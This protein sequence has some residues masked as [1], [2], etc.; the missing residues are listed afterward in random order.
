MLG[1]KRFQRS[2]RRLRTGW[3]VCFLLLFLSLAAQG[4]QTVEEYYVPLPEEQWQESLKTISS[5]TSATIDS[6]ISIVVWGSGTVVYYD[7]WEDGY[8]WKINAPTQPG[9]E[10]WGDGNDA[11]GKPPSFARDP[12][13]LSKGAVIILR[14]LVNVPRD[15]SVLYDGRDRFASSRPLSVSRVG[16]AT[17]PNTNLSN[18]GY[19]SAVIDYGLHFL[20]PVGEDVTLDG[21]FKYAGLLVMA[22]NDDTSVEIDKDGPGPAAAE[23]VYLDQGE[24]HLVNGGVLKGASVDTS[25]PVQAHLI[26]GDNT[27]TYESRA[28]TLFPD[29]QWANTYLSPVG[30]SLR[31][32]E[33][34]AFLYNPNGIPITIDI[35]TS[36]GTDH[37]QVPAQSTSHWLI[38]NGSGARFQSVLGEAF[39]ALT[40]VNAGAGTLWEWG[41]SLLPDSVLTTETVIGWAPGSDD[42]TQNGS[43]VYICPT[44]DTR[45]YADFNGD[46][47]GSQIDPEG[48][49]YDAAYDVDAYAS[50]TLRDPDNDHTGMRIYT[51]DDVL[52]AAAWG[53]DCEYADVNPPFM[54]VGGPI[55]PG[56]VLSLVKDSVVKLDRGMP[57]LSIGDVVEYSLT[58]YNNG[59]R[60]LE[61]VELTDMLPGGLTYRANSTKF[62]DAPVLDDS[63]GFT[64]F[65][66]DET[67]YAV[68]YLP[69][70]TTAVLT[71][72]TVIDV[73]GTI[74][75]TAR[76]S[77]Y[78]VVSE[79][80]LN[81]PETEGEF[82][83][84]GEGEVEPATYGVKL[85]TCSA[86]PNPVYASQQI[87]LS[88]LSGLCHATTA[89]E[90]VRVTLGFRD[91]SGAWAGNDPVVVYSGTP[92][93]SWQKWSNS[94]IFK[95]PSA[96]G[97]YAVWVRHSPGMGSAAAIQ[98]FKDAVPTTA[99]EV[100]D[101]TWDK[102][103]IVVDA[104]GEGE[105]GEGETPSYGLTVHSCT[106]TPN[107]VDPGM[108]V[109]LAG[110][111]GQCYAATDS[112]TLKITA[113]FRDASGVWKGGE[114]V[115]AW[116]GKP[117]VSPLAW[118]GSA[119]VMAPSQPGTYYIWVRNTATTSDSAA[120]TDFKNAAAP[121][122]DETRNDRFETPLTVSPLQGIQLTQCAF[123]PNPAAPGQKVTLS[124]VGGQYRGPS[125]SA[126][127]KITTGFRD[128]SGAW[129][130]SDPA[131]VK[132]GIPGTTW[133]AWTGSTTLIAPLTA[134]TYQVWVRST[135][136]TSDRDA[137]ADFKAVSPTSGDRQFNDTW[138]TS[139][140]IGNGG[141]EGE[142]G[143]GESGEGELAEGEEIPVE[144]EGEAETPA[145]CGC[146]CNGSKNLGG[147]LNS[148]QWLGDLLVLG[149]AVMILGVYRW[150][151]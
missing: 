72:E 10:V 21:L 135:A 18:M 54:D 146:G 55:L 105:P 32:Y 114:P 33:S 82:P 150:P 95:A 20:C 30:T 110:L 8:E 123:S 139:L 120:V 12:S 9:T 90:L 40:A 79:N 74:T 26:T 145:G 68:F 37:L 31:D 66:L 109:T 23:V 41:F 42:P 62:N 76:L 121:T 106:I 131:V 124:G 63:T 16:W 14:N 70:D 83:A 50:Q 88:D 22:S 35:E 111:A 59:V 19:M 138:A 144:G 77:Q 57:G 102:P 115:V 119:T 52:F 47:M 99:D 117:G 27:V 36:G 142:S 116:T 113:G 85:E 29:Q 65:P 136:T 98:D 71:Y 92:G 118:S 48:G 24:S 56:P 130:G 17:I 53:E 127:V 133:K 4:V 86:S 147:P 149:I 132:T 128:A 151:R 126:T 46:H 125:A 49:N 93:T 89:G 75:N 78:G 3:A 143:E 7:H 101:D 15:G 140:I 43:S 112:Q 73:S 107:P 94:V 13:G 5:D 148:L 60:N 1:M 137:L 64:P 96:A 141:I 100:R 6:I 108:P 129:A 87:S 58:V 61:T 2:E 80:T 84:E 44:H 34:Y 51:L 28:F 67:G 81:V 97:T 38:P 91:P 134:G 103:I 39:Q 45:I 11:N 69:R 122:P 25:K 104:P